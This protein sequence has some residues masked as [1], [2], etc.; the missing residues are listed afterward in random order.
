MY[1][2]N[3]IKPRILLELEKIDESQDRNNVIE[4]LKAYDQ[5]SNHYLTID[6]YSTHKM[7]DL[8]KIESFIE[9]FI[10]QN[11]EICEE[12]MGM[13]ETIRQ[14]RIENLEHIQK[15]LFHTINLIKKEV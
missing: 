7:T 1:T 9:K 14:N 2:L 11:I 15:V 8:E 5:R 12:V 3:E 13:D 6:L 4:N 10:D